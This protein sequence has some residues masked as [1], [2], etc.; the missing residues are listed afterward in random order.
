[1]LGRSC[2]SSIPT[3]AAPDDLCCIVPGKRKRHDRQATCLR[4]FQCGTQLSAGITTSAS[5]LALRLPDHAGRERK[6]HGPRHQSTVGRAGTRSELGA[7]SARGK[8]A[9]SWLVIGFENGTRATGRPRTRLGNVTPQRGWLAAASACVPV[10]IDD[11]RSAVSSLATRSDRSWRAVRAASRSTGRKR[12]CEPGA[13][14]ATV[15][16]S[17]LITV[18]IIA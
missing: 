2:S 5:N 12:V 9:R 4:S 15:S 11:Q 8:N 17:A 13:D 10:R 3:A 16:M 14:C 7:M 1:M 6:S 18:A